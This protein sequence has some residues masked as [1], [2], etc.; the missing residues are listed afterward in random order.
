M[1]EEFSINWTRQR[2]ISLRKTKLKLCRSAI[3]TGTGGGAADGV[4]GDASAA[5]TGAMAGGAGVAVAGA[6]GFG[7]GHIE[8]RKLRS[9]Q[10]VEFG[11]KAAPSSTGPRRSR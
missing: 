11:R 9:D 10:N 3:V 8:L 5:A 2:E 1:A 7:I 4:F 6:Y